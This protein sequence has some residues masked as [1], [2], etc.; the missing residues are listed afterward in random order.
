M[1]KVEHTREIKL[2]EYTPNLIGLQLITDAK[3]VLVEEPNPNRK[4]HTLWR[5]KNGQLLLTHSSSTDLV[6]LKPILI[7]ETE[8]IEVGDWYYYPYKHQVN[9]CK[10]LNGKALVDPSCRK[11]LALPE[12]FSPKHLQAI[13]DGKLKDGDKILV[14]CEKPEY[15]EWRKEEVFVDWF[16]IKLNPHITI[17]HSTTLADVEEKMYTREEVINLIED[18]RQTIHNY[19]TWTY[20]PKLWFEQNVK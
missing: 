12:H 18:Y 14:E 7:S 9:Q 5:N 3:L 19:G 4:E 6:A 10:G 1:I 2:S 13:V 16:K 20:S 8:K 17:Y 15:N 11:I